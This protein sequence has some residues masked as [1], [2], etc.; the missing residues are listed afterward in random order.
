MLSPRAFLGTITAFQ[1]FLCLFL[2]LPTLKDEIWF[3]TLALLA[4][5]ATFLA[6]RLTRRPGLTTGCAA[7]LL[8]FAL[9]PL[10]YRG[11]M[12][13]SLCAIFAGTGVIAAAVANLLPP[14]PPRFE[15]KHRDEPQGA[16]GE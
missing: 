1:G 5:G 10:G 3:T 11:I 2:V 4:G 9:A 6:A 14:P 16:T 15:R 7:A 13:W 8:A 12:P